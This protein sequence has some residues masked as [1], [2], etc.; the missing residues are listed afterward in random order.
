MFRPIR[1]KE[2]RPADN[3]RVLGSTFSQEGLLS[4]DRTSQGL[5]RRSADYVDKILRGDEAGDIPVEQPT[6]FSN[7]II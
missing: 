5:F 1:S 6:N 4:T 2:A 3:A 7:V